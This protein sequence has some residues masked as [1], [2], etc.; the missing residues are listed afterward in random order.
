MKLHF[1]TRKGG[2][3][4][5]FCPCLFSPR[6]LYF[7]GWGGKTMHVALF[8]IP[9][10]LPHSPAFPRRNRH[11]SIRNKRLFSC[12]KCVEINFRRRKR[13]KKRKEKTV[14]PGGKQKRPKKSN[15]VMQKVFFVCAVLWGGPRS[16]CYLLYTAAAGKKRRGFFL[17][18]DSGRRRR[19][20][21]SEWGGSGFRD[22]EEE[23]WKEDI[24]RGGNRQASCQFRG[25]ESPID[26]PQKRQ[27]IYIVFKNSFLCSILCVWE[28]RVV[29]CR[30]G[31]LFRG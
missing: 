17:W 30:P 14:Q 25:L 7:C 29:L 8:F 19:R 24:R 15:I 9:L 16:C 31:N 28:K 10:L 4:N 2:T 20:E 22:K 12:G 3:D 6:G 13:R 18:A 27:R 21:E 23:Q 26:Y 11:G 1:I 5:I